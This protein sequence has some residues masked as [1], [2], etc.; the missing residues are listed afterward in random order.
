MSVFLGVLGSIAGIVLGVL[1]IEGNRNNSD[2]TAELA[3]VV[4]LFGPFVGYAI[5]YWTVQGITWV[6]EGF[7][8][9]PDAKQINQ[10][11]EGKP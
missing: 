5:P 11:H 6:V 10:A 8:R 9:T 7:L 4:A 2:G 3:V 1:I